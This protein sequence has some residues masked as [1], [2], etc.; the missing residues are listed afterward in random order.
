MSH[1]LYTISETFSHRPELRNQWKQLSRTTYEG[2]ANIP[3]SC[4]LLISKNEWIN[5]LKNNHYIDFGIFILYPN[6]DMDY[7]GF[8]YDSK[9]NRYV[10]GK[11]IVKNNIISSFKTMGT[12]KGYTYQDVININK[13]L[14]PEIPSKFRESGLKILFDP[15]TTFQILTNRNICVETIKNYAREMVLDQFEEIIDRL[16][17]TNSLRLYIVMNDY[18]L[19]G[20]VPKVTRE[21]RINNIRMEI[22]SW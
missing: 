18:Y 20:S 19:F 15:Y 1:S 12:D 5:Y 11:Y 8:K 17:G 21:H 2:S 16:E 14:W 7:I 3:E 4:N 6:N 10:V 22:L 13:I 9:Y